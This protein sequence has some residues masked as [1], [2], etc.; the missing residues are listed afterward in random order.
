MNTAAILAALTFVLF[1]GAASFGPHRVQI[2]LMQASLEDWCIVPL[3]GM[4]V[5]AV[6][7]W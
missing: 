2:V 5:L 1:I 7:G 3:F 6:V 4:V